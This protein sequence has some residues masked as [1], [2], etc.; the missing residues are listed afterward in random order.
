MAKNGRR[1]K[2]KGKGIRARDHAPPRVSLA[3]KTPFPFPFKRPATQARASCQPPFAVV[4]RQH[5]TTW[6]TAFCLA[7][8]HCLLQQKPCRNNWTVR[9]ITRAVIGQLLWQSYSWKVIPQ[10]PNWTPTKLVPEVFLEIF[11][12][13]RESEPRSGNNESRETPKVL[14]PL[15]SELGNY[16]R[17]ILRLN[18]IHNTGQVFYR[19]IC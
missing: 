10:I 12:R 5:H 15:L 17:G 4:P 13:E 9:A 3:P 11:L 6:R 7:F 16:Q 14:L 2:G 1:S 8:L 18:Y 19:Y